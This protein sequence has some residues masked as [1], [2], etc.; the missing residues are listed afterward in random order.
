MIR[1]AYGVSLLT[2]AVL[3]AYA[4]GAIHGGVAGYGAGLRPEPPHASELIVLALGQSPG[5]SLV[6]VL[7]TLLGAVGSAILFKSAGHHRVVDLV[8]GSRSAVLEA[9]SQEEPALSPLE[10]VLGTVAAFSA[11]CCGLVICGLVESW[12]A[13]TVAVLSCLAGLETLFGLVLVVMV[14]IQRP[15]S[16]ALFATAT[17]AVLLEV[18]LI[19]SMILASTT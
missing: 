19:A 11:A 17:V 12:A 10:V 7:I 5:L 1:I 9:L 8:V 4:F 3:A 18:A 16:L 13:E 15:R 14:I 6:L 2:V